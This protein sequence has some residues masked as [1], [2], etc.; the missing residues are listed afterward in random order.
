MR[1]FIMPMDG[2]TIGAVVYELNNIKNLIKEN[3]TVGIRMNAD[4]Y[5]CDDL[6]KLVKEI[7]DT[8]GKTPKLHM[9]CYPI[10][11]TDDYQRTE[12]EKQILFSKLT[13]LEE[14]VYLCG[15]STHSP[16]NVIASKQCMAD[17][18]DSITIS[19]NGEFGVCEHFIDSDFWGNINNSNKD[20]EIFKSWHVY[21]PKLDICSDCPLYGSC[22]RPSKCVEMRK[23][24]LYYKHWKILKE[25]IG[26]RN[27]YFKSK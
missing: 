23:C 20:F 16:N 14:L 9:Y 21:E 19:P 6:M 24:D 2:L 17:S 11:E 26:L 10:F 22:I 3:I 15:Y 18:G 27:L 5:N 4:T 1:Y 25:K 7:S 8:F 13:D 12:E